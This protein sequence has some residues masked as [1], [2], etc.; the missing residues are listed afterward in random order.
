MLSPGDIVRIYPESVSLLVDDISTVAYGT[1]RRSRRRLVIDVTPDESITDQL[2]LPVAASNEQFPVVTAAERDAGTHRLMR[3]FVVARVVDNWVLGQVCRADHASRSIQVRTHRGRLTMRQDAVALV[4]PV[5]AALLWDTDWSALDDDAPRSATGLT[6]EALLECHRRIWHRIRPQTDL[7]APSRDIAAI[8]AGYD[9]HNAVN[10]GTLRRIVCDPRSG[11]LVSPS[12]QHIVDFT[13]HADGGANDPNIVELGES[14]CHDPSDSGIDSSSL[15]DEAATATAVQSPM[16]VVSASEHAAGAATYAGIPGHG[17]IAPPVAA[18]AAEYQREHRA[19]SRAAATRT[20]A[21]YTEVASGPKSALRVSPAQAEVHWWITNAQYQTA[22]PMEFLASVARC[23]AI[24]FPPHPGTLNLRSVWNDDARVSLSHFP[25]SLT[26]PKPRHNFCTID[27]IRAA[28]HALLAYANTF[29]SDILVAVVEAALALALELLDDTDDFPDSA[30]T[31]VLQWFNERFA[32]FGTL[33]AMA[34]NGNASV[35]ASISSFPTTFATEG[36]AYQNL[37]LRVLKH[38][39]RDSAP[40][41]SYLDP[42]KGVEPLGGGKQKATHGRGAGGNR[43]H[44][45]PTR[46]PGRA[47]ERRR[48]PDA[49]TPFVPCTNP[50]KGNTCTG[51]KDRFQ[52]RTRTSIQAQSKRAQAI[53]KLEV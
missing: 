48:S 13:F 27:N 3:R 38:A 36:P 23:E 32:A 25:V 45:N 41:T 1:V 7:E 19:R 46:C 12:V 24:R 18:F 39:L 22:M 53:S 51:Y 21:Q 9:V 28:L 35:V 17:G 5:V 40:P 26:P 34:A 8:L 49:P 2:S 16:P 14:F 47:S 31:I 33:L 20:L 52:D 10:L 44:A 30:T 4:L 43:K 15:L 29:G 50:V 37:F 11:L 42:T 6:M